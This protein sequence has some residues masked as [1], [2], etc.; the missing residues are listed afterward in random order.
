MMKEIVK[1]E[2]LIKKYKETTAVNNI[3]FTVNKGEVLVIIGSSGS[4]KSTVLRCMNQLEEIN[5]G[6]IKIDNYE[7][8]KE[9]KNGKPVYNNKDILKQM[10]LK[11]GF[12][13]QNFNLFPHKTILENVTEAMKIV[14]KMDESTS[15]EKA[16]K[17]LE[18]MGIENKKDEYPCNLSGGQKQ[19]ASIARALAIEP[20]ILF[21]DEPTSALDPELTGEVLK[22][23]KRLADEKTTMVIVTHEIQF[24]QQIADRIIFMDKG[25]I[26]ETG[27]PNDIIKNP[28]EK[29]TREFLKRYLERV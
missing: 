28:K 5:G 20:E 12:V 14:L 11:C 25:T 27:T 7:M 19:R 22:V 2:N 24:A 3:S 13:F 26:I 23:I 16:I 8:I 21:M 10:N 15:E 9:Y 6:N 17:L 18:K 1:V 29:R 4:G